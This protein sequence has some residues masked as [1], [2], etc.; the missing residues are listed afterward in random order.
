MT[1]C[2]FFLILCVII[3]ICKSFIW[4]FQVSQMVQNRPAMLKTQVQ[5]LSQDNTLEK[6][7]A[8]HFSILAWGSPWT[9]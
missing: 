1:G 4:I 7:M 2:T 6:G 8:T 9:G 5:S 3:Y